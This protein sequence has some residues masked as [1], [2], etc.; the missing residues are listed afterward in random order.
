[1]A[2]FTIK[3]LRKLAKP[4]PL[5]FANHVIVAHFDLHIGPLRLSRCVLTRGEDTGFGVRMP[6]RSVHLDPIV[7]GEVKRAVRAAFLGGQ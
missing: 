6:A 4:V 1:M 3:R 2:E 7:R 5:G